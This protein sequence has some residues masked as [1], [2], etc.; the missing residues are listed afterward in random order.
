METKYPNTM[1]S[2]PEAAVFK[3]YFKSLQEFCYLM[4]LKLLF[5]WGLYPTK[6]A[7]FSPVVQ[8][9]NKM[10]WKEQE[11]GNVDFRMFIA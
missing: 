7:S 6:Q 5:S 9:E 2:V 4:F 3:I 8:R 11:N 10:V 1:H